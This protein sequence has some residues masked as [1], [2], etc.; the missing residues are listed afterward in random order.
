MP[1]PLMTKAE[2]SRHRG[3]SRARVIQWIKTGKVIVT[4]EGLVDSDKSDN[5]LESRPW[6]VQTRF[7]TP[8]VKPVKKADPPLKTVKTKKP[9][10][11]REPKKPK[12]VKPEPQKK[13]DRQPPPQPKVIPLLQPPPQKERM[14]YDKARTAKIAYEAQIKKM[15]MEEKQGSLVSKDQVT[16]EAFEIG[17]KVRDAFLNIPGR[18]GPILAAEKD[19][20]KVHALLLKEIEAVL[21]M[22]AERKGK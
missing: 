4:G 16:K 21:E 15:E 20:Q 3:C 6:T 11:V 9:K 8:K 10:P 12:T 18:I 17:R 19:Q 14:T 2:Y 13:G 7:I 5:N 1:L 22:L